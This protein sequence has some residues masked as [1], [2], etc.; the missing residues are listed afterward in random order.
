T[1]FYVRAHNDF[2]QAFAERGILGGLAF[3]GIFVLGFVYAFR[4]L[5][6]SQDKAG[7]VRAA[8]ALMGLTVWVVIGNFSFPFERPMSFLLLATFFGLAFSFPPTSPSF[9]KLFRQVPYGIAA[10]LAA[11]AVL[12]TSMT[13]ADAGTRELREAKLSQNWPRVIRLADKATHWYQ[14]SER[15][16]FTPIAWY[17]GTALLSMNRAAEAVPNLEHAYAVH[18][19]HP[20][21]LSNYGTALAATGQLEKAITIYEKLLLVFPQF[22]DAR[23]NLTEIYLSTNN[24]EGAQKQVDYWKSVGSQAG[25]SVYLEQVSKRLQLMKP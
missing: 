11:F 18:P 23:R 7:Q 4:A 21:V 15:L 19:Y 6:Q 16:S 13:L 1:R 9:P 24:P 8:I 20:H 5:E 22:D 2:L 25:I 3:L 14:P 17:R 10:L 12:L